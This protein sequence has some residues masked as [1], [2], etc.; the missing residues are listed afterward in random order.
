MQRW[1]GDLVVA[2]G[3]LSAAALPE[4]ERGEGQHRLWIGRL[5]GWMVTSYE[6]RQAANPRA[7]PKRCTADH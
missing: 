5:A 2:C 6:G 1:Q 7:H 3:R 4:R